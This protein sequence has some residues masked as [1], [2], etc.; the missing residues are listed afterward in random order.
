MFPVAGLSP[1]L[2]SVVLAHSRDFRPPVHDVSD[3]DNDS[4]NDEQAGWRPS[5]SGVSR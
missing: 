4:R 5:K 2:G 3:D 1:V